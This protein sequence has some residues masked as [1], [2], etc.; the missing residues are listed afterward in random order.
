M[1]PFLLSI[2]GTTETGK[3]ISKTYMT[4]DFDVKCQRFQSHGLVWQSKNVNARD[5]VPFP[6]SK[7]SQKESRCGA[8]PSALIESTEHFLINFHQLLF[9]GTSLHHAIDAVFMGNTIAQLNKHLMFRNVITCVQLFTFT[10]K[11]TWWKLLTFWA[12]LTITHLWI[13]GLPVSVI[14]LVRFQKGRIMAKQGKIQ[15]QL[16]PSSV[17]FRTKTHINGDSYPL[18]T[19]CCLQSWTEALYSS[20]LQLILYVLSVHLSNARLYDVP[21]TCKQR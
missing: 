17:Y 8:A 19:L 6:F 18:E 21:S 20:C 16:T 12:K 2:V 7:L 13:C 3:M 14:I 4:V 5:H 15:N 10:N 9:H 1:T 11:A